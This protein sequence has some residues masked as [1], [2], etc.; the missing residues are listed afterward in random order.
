REDPRITIGRPIDNTTVYVL[1]PQGEPVPPGVLGEL[2][3][4]GTGVSH[5]YLH[6]PELNEARFVRDPFSPSSDARMYKTGDLVAF[7]A[8]GQL[9]Y[10]RRL[11]H[12]VKVRGYRIELGEIESVLAEHEAIDQSVVIVREDRAGDARLVV[13]Y[14]LR[15]GVR[16]LTATDLRKHLRKR[17]PE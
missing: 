6:R 2:V 13:Y 4:G 17:L 12:Q 1:D 10:H 5:G 11:D 3:I 9:V 8:D 14:V 15:A 16:A 7:R